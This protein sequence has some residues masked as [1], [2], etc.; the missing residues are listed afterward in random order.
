MKKTAKTAYCI[1]YKEKSMSP[2]T[3]LTKV[4]T[5]K[6]A[7][8]F[9]DFCQFVEAF[10]F[11][12]DHVCNNHYIYKKPA[13]SKL[14]SIQNYKDHAKPCQIRQFLN[15]IQKYKLHVEKWL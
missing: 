4:L 13:I 9:E 8:R 6:K 2:Q 12:L 10:G 11:E 14:I 15:I 5:G 7:V 3:I 1:L